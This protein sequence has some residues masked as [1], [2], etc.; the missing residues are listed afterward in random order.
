MVTGYFDEMHRI[1]KLFQ[2]VVK[3]RTS[4]LQADSEDEAL[5]DITLSDDGEDEVIDVDMRILTEKKLRVF[6]EHLRSTPDTNQV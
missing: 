6:L 5:D 3:P 4:V 1:K 2:V